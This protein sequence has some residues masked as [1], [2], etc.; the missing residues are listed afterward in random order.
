MVLSLSLLFV[1]HMG[2]IIN[3]LSIVPTIPNLALYENSNGL[4]PLI[5]ACAHFGI[6]PLTI[7][8]PIRRRL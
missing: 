2:H 1:S 4:D 8:L 7:R 3:F 5:C 6:L